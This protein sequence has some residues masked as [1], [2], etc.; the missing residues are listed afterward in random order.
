MW[1]A[2]GLLLAAAA[3]TAVWI[4]GRAETVVLESELDRSELAVGVD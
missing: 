2:A 1:V 3:F 4:P